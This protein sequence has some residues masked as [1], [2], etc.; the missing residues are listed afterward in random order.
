[1]AANIN[2]VTDTTFQIEVLES[3]TPVLV[4]FWAPWCGPCRVI[5]PSLE[6]IADEQAESLRIVKVNVDENQQTAA[7][8]GILA[9]PTLLLFRNGAEAK[10]IQGA[11]PKKRLEAELA[12]GL[13]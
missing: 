10:R 4:D 9:I 2:D 11:L 3:E 12:S 6:E 1:M 8:F 13:A 5:A 7:Q